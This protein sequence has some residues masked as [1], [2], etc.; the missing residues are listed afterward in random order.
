MK[1]DFRI[2]TF[3]ATFL[4]V[5]TF[6]HA[7]E[8]DIRIEKPTGRKFAFLVGVTEY[9]FPNHFPTLTYTVQDVKALQKQLE[10]VGF[11]PENIVVMAS[12]ESPSQRPEK[13]RILAKMNE[14][15]QKTTENDI[16][17]IMFSGHGTQIGKDQFFC[18]EDAQVADLAGSCVSL[19]EVLGKMKDANAKFKWLIVDACRNDPTKSTADGVKSIGKLESVPKGVTAIFSCAETEKSYEDPT[20]GHGVFTHFLMRGLEGKA[21]NKDS[22]V[23]ILSLYEYVQK[24]TQA[25]VKSKYTQSQI[26]YWNGDFT[27]FIVRDDL[28]IEG[29]PREQ[30]LQAD[31]AYKQSQEYRRKKEYANASAEIKKAIAILPNKREFLDEKQMIDLLI[32]GM[33]P[34]TGPSQTTPPSVAQGSQS[35]ESPK[36][37]LVIPAMDKPEEWIKPLKE[38]NRED[39]KPVVDTARHVQLVIYADAAQDNRLYSQAKK[40]FFACQVP[41]FSKGNDRIDWVEEILPSMIRRKDFEG[42]KACTEDIVTDMVKPSGEYDFAG[43]RDWALKCGILGGFALV[44]G[45]A[46]GAKSLIWSSTRGSDAEIS[47][48]IAAAVANK[49]IFVKD[50]RVWMDNI[51]FINYESTSKEYKNRLASKNEA[52]WGD[53]WFVNGWSDDNSFIFSTVA[54]RMAKYGKKEEYKNFLSTANKTFK[55][56]KLKYCAYNFAMAEAILG[57]F[58]RARNQWMQYPTK[59]TGPWPQVLLSFIVR[60]E[61]LAGEFKG[62]ETMQ[63]DKNNIEN[64]R[65]VYKGDDLSYSVSQ[66]YFDYGRGFARHKTADEIKTEWETLEAKFSK[67]SKSGKS[68]LAFFMAGVATGLQDRKRR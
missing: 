25:Y 24:E 55:N 56:D 33:T 45:D 46:E 16:I 10:V 47:L 39:I 59:D 14:L 52:I 43:R 62:W 54:I 15:L 50:N 2:L 37:N 22:V 35:Q 11:E 30:W 13:R 5:A 23:T 42:L 53:N 6:S 29:V 17:I 31:A 3:L 58:D 1:P 38:L 40:D 12:R 48:A 9:E 60:Q 63:R 4:V 64:L 65:V 7:Q 66:F 19:N 32:A 41:N 28:L 49:R 68:D 51:M 44:Y 26:P 8:R 18:P 34:P 27:N 61:F 36:T 67:D 20:L 57:D 21:A